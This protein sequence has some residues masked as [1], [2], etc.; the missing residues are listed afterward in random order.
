M[1]PYSDAMPYV[2]PRRPFLQ[3][4]RLPSGAQ[5]RVQRAEWV[6][7]RDGA[8][9]YE[10]AQRT[11]ERKRLKIER[12]RNARRVRRIVRRWEQ[13]VTGAQERQRHVAAARIQRHWRFKREFAAELTKLH[14]MLAFQGASL[15]SGRK[16]DAGEGAA[17]PAAGALVSLQRKRKAATLLQARYRRDAA[18]MPPRD[19]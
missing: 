12:K 11:D 3:Y 7:A 13:M 16:A 1:L 8:R 9:R 15:F 17:D 19:I 6:Q 18:G 5:V 2:I 10:L 4:P 14:A